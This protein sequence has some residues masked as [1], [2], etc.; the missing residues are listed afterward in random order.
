MPSLTC[1]ENL[2]QWLT[3]MLSPY[4]ATTN[5]QP[6]MFP[7]SCQL[8]YLKSTL[9]MDASFKNESTGITWLRKLYFKY[10]A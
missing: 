1:W 5:S 3:N 7:K 9:V 2:L 8:R 4:D 6:S 10:Y